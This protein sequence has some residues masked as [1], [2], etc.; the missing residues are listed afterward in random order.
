MK[1]LLILFTLITQAS[2]TQTVINM[3]RIGGVSIIPC[4]VN[5]LNLSFIFDTGASDVSISLT[6]AIYMIRNGMLSK[7]DILGVAKYSNANGE[8]SEGYVINLKE[9]EFAGLKLYNIRASITK[10]INA[11]LLL[12]QSALSKIGAFQL[13]L[14]KN[15]LTIFKGKG[16]FDYTGYVQNYKPAQILNVED[17]D[18]TNGAP[19]D[20]TVTNYKNNYLDNVM[21]VF[22]SKS[23]QTEYQG[24]TTNGKLFLHLPVGDSYDIIVIDNKDYSN[25]KLEIPRY[26]SSPLKVDIHFSDPNPIPSLFF[27]LGRCPHRP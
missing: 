8:I 16:R 11:P 10:N 5:G 25:S 18:N 21:V 13:D 1:Y 20:V 17:R 15:T 23:T 14:D 6:E 4:K 3:Q 26:Y 22:K 9:I 19:V 27:F 12:G 24:Y 2:F 7:D